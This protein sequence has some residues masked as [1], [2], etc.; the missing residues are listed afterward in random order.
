MAKKNQPDD[1]QQIRARIREC[2]HSCLQETYIDAKGKEVTG[3]EAI[4][5][6]VIQKGL[7]RNDKDQ[8]AAIKYIFFMLGIE[9][10]DDEVQKDSNNN[11][12]LEAKIIQSFAGAA[13]S[14]SMEGS[15]DS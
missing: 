14:V 11:K 15:D 1:T 2:F 7:N 8:F 12:S 10:T 3:Y 6:Q 5:R 13:G 4:V 9:K